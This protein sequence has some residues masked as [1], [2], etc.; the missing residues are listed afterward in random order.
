MEFIKKSV[1]VVLTVL[2]FSFCAT[3][4][5]MQMNFPQEIAKTY[6]ETLAVDSQRQAVGVNFHVEFKE[7]LSKDIHLQKV[8]FRNQEAI[9]EKVSDKKYVAHF[10]QTVMPQDIILDSD[11]RKEYGNKAP[12][13]VTPK[14]KL[15][16]DEAV[17]EY[18]KNNETIFF[19]LKEIK[20][21]Q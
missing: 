3:N 10:S 19:K 8:Y 1:F 21:K 13:I 16:K 14:F 4:N 15:N 2:C 9:I 7:P 18:K 12:I 5:Q 20:E 17:L 11:S 6:Y